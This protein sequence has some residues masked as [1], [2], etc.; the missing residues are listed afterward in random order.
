MDLR[1]G[2][3]DRSARWSRQLL[4][5]DDTYQGRVVEMAVDA[6]QGIAGAAF[7]SSTR[8][9][10]PLIAGVNYVEAAALL[11]EFVARVP[12]QIPR[13]S[14]SSKSAWMAVSSPTMYETQAQLTDAYLAPGQG[15]KRA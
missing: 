1:A 8:R 15:R 9:S 2:Q 5:A 10:T 3:L 11:Q 4:A 12:G 6:R 13:C 7:L 14:S